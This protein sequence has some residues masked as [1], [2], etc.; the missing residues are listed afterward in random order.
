MALSF[1]E[2]KDT[3]EYLLAGDVWR[4]ADDTVWRYADSISYRNVETDQVCLWERRGEP[5]TLQDS[6]AVVVREYAP[7]KDENDEYEWAKLTKDQ[8]GMRDA[9]ERVVGD[10]DIS[11]IL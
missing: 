11:E 10:G 2:T 6:E 8:R 9:L 7:L 3:A 1:T 5:I 4:R